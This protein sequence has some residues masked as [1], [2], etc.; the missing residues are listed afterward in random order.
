MIYQLGVYLLMNETQIRSCLM[1]R[2]NNFGNAGSPHDKFSEE[3]SNVVTITNADIPASLRC[4]SNAS[5][6]VC[7]TNP[8]FLDN[9]E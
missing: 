1:P 7:F 4:T 8:N 3:N 9:E 6:S 2:T 5:W